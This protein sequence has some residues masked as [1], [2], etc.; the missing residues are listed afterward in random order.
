[1]VRLME[2]EM[3]SINGSPVLSASPSS[4]LDT[5]PALS[6]S[7]SISP[8]RSFSN[9]SFCTSTSSRSSARSCSLPSASSRR[10]GY[11]RPQGATFA[12]SAQNRDSVLSLGSIAHLQYYFARTGLLDGKGGQLAKQK[13][14]GEYDLPIPTRFSL[15]RTGSDAGSSVIES[16]IE[17]EGALLWDAAQE[18]G[19]DVM[20]PPT[21]STYAHRPH[22]VTPPPDQKSL[23]KDLVE[24]LENALHALE[25][26]TSS[27][28]IGEAQECQDEVD[29][30]FYEIQG[31]HIL[32]TTTLAIRAAR[33]YYTLHPNPTVLNSFKPDLQIRRDLI[34][35]LDVLKKWASRKFAGGL[36]EDER[37]AILVWVSEVG[38]M[39]DQE[40][41]V[42]EAERQER[43]GWQWMDDSLW[44]GRGK[45]REVCFME[46]L[47]K[48][49]QPL[50]AQ[51]EL[52][53]WTQVDD[54][55]VGPSPFLKAL[56]DGRKLVQMH[57][58]AVKRSKRQFGEIK[59]WHED[60]LKPYRRAEN[61][62]F[63]IKAA[64]I[65]WETKLAVNVMCVVNTAEEADVWRSFEDAVLKWSKGVREEII[66]DW[67]NDEERKL[68]ARAKSLALASPAGS[69]QKSKPRRGVL[70]EQV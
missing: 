51:D 53:P 28:R 21:V 47:L 23:K 26:T 66:R 33:L 4:S 16:P 27:P 7:S 17:E 11:I 54:C 8:I 68:H 45:Q 69:P 61:M 22:H 1:M 57:N 15:S 35:V 3:P 44:S 60:V 20:L 41:R 10:R 9:G 59:A 18:D 40:A 5:T 31:L 58:A 13:Q 63:W 49:S 24:A 25:S 12:P 37:L 6:P 19:E 56:A 14:N 62:R 42:E 43:E 67:K 38:M 70:D 34:S 46:S 30:G 65:R 50:Q 29:Q 32:D 64:E 55:P 52:P 36:R 48:A 2:K 39:I